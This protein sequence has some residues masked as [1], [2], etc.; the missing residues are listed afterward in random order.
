MN[1]L[2]EWAIALSFI[3]LGIAFGTLGALTLWKG[4]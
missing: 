3:A 1:W 4:W 2:V